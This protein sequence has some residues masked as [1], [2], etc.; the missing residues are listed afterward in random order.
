MQKELPCSATTLASGIHENQ[1]SFEYVN[2]LYVKYVCRDFH[3]VPENH[4]TTISQFIL[5]TKTN[6]IP[7]F[8][9]DYYVLFV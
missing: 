5:I 7:D 1:C 2:D 3:I 6:V 9:L 8:S 4:K